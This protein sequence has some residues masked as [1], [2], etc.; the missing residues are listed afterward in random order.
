MISL[1]EEMHAHLAK[2]IL[3][4]W[5]E[6]T[7][8]A[9]Y[10]GFIGRIDGKDA[11]HPHADKG[12]I[13]NARILWTFSA[14]YHQLKDVQYLHIAQRAFDYFTSRFFDR[15]FGGVYWSVDYLGHAKADKKQVYAQA[16][17]MY[18]LAAYHQ[19][20]HDPLALDLAIDL[21]W[22]IEKH[23]FD[24]QYNG[25]LEAFDREWHLLDDLRLSEKDAN[26]KKTMNTHLHILEAYTTLFR[27][28]KDEHLR[29]QLHNLITLF[30]D[31]FVN[32]QYRFNL[33]FDEKWNLK[34]DEISFGHD[35]EGSWLLQEAAEVLGDERLMQLTRAN[36][37]LMVDE[38]LR[39]GF[40][41]DGGLMYEADQE[42]V[43]DTDKHW[44]PQAEAIVGLAN[45]WQNTRDQKYLLKAGYVWRFIQARMI[46]RAGG[47]WY[48][49]VD[50]KGQ[51][52]ADEDKAGPWKCPYHNGRACLEMIKRF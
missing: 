37:N 30:L 9:V 49:K 43:T 51:P 41:A 39:R 33:F 4:Y 21:F 23:A 3:P 40:D 20:A 31:K 29:Q 38:V 36:A 1:K 16:F 14:A 7:I 15:E 28:W 47:E 44:W 27:S 10:G 52:Y 12:C 19:S 22:L 11:P 50:K 34:S 46:D 24:Q 45:A 18:G 32:R 5:S 26:E 2:D 35:I 48:F 13:L 25:Y 6:N 8:D 42:R 17:A